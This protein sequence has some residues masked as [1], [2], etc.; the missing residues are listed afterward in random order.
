M[1]R[2]RSFRSLV[3]F[4]LLL[5]G[6]PEILAQRSE[7]LEMQSSTTPIQD[8]KVQTLTASLAMT[9]GASLVLSGDTLMAG[10]PFGTI[11]PGVVHIQRSSGAAWEAIASLRAPDAIVGDEFGR[12]LA[13]HGS[14]LVVG[15]PGQY[16]G[17]GAAYLFE[18]GSLGW[19]FKQ[20]LVTTGLSPGARFG[21][22]VAIDGDRIAVGAPGHTDRGAVITFRRTGGAW[23]RDAELT[24]DQVS[25][26]AN[27]GF[28]VGLT[29]SALWASAPYDQGYT[30]AIV[31]YDGTQQAW[32]EVGVLRAEEARGGEYFGYGLSVTEQGIHVGRLQFQNLGDVLIYE[33]PSAGQL[34][35]NPT[36]IMNPVTSTRGWFGYSLAR[37][38]D[39]LIV[40][41]P[42]FDGQVGRAYLYRLQNDQ[43]TL[44]SETLDLTAAQAGDRLG[45][46]VA[47]SQAVA[48]AGLYGGGAGPGV[49]ASARRVSG[50]W[51][52]SE[53]LEGAGTPEITGA[54]VRC[55]NGVAG[56]FPCYNVDLHAFLPKDQVG[57]LRATKL[58]DVWG[59]TDDE[60]GSKYVLSAR[61]DGLSIVMVDDPNHPLFLAQLPMTEGSRA[62]S[63]R[64]VK[65][66]GHYAL[67][68]GDNVGPHGMQVLD[69]TVLRTL[70]PTDAP[71]MLQ[72]TTIYRGFEEAHNIVVNNAFER[73]Y[74]VGT[75]T[76]GAGYHVIDMSD[77][78]NP[79]QIGCY[80]TSGV[81][82]SGTGYV[83]D[84]QCVRY[85]GPDLSHQG[86]D[87]CFGSN[88]THV[89]IT[90]F[91]TPSS[92]IDL[93]LANY[94]DYGYVHQAWLSD[95]HRYLYQ[96][97]ELDE[98]YG[99]IGQRT[100]V[101]DVEDLDDP[102]LDTVYA[103]AVVPTTDH[104]LY[105]R[106]NRVYEGN[107]ASGMRILDI[108]NP[109]APQ[110]IA[111][112]DTHPIKN[113]VGFDGVW[114]VYPFFED[115]PI[116][117]SSRGE[118]LF[119][120]SEQSASTARRPDT[121]PRAFV[122]APYPQPALGTVTVPIV[123]PV[124][125]EVSWTLIDV[126]GRP[127]QSG[128][129]TVSIGSQ[130]LDVDLGDLASGTYVLTL[131]QGQHRLGVRMI[132]K[133]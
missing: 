105:V 74:A 69:L 126:L 4:C 107:Y 108:S 49:I 103:G 117:I 109:R 99:G 25:P 77:P 28:R 72:E 46:A 24:S 88:E 81:G 17:R 36:H 75:E 37:A 124:T 78:T 6:V 132:T 64:D 12:A 116:V 60:T 11:E 39:A 50:S 98:Y 119:F 18:Y 87:I 62:N 47:L 123:V 115:G 121:L 125:G 21:F 31:Q 120:V 51:V 54:D 86:K 68:V 80:G 96:N 95:D 15:A 76:C 55:T 106:G 32:K 131:N 29:G 3:V 20:S 22:S 118:G 82:F 43:W 44:E 102:I 114:S 111:Y 27:L 7:S 53:P 128:E 57:A 13:T 56:P 101:W 34:A 10:A 110:E 112:F 41:Q 85:N 5:A 89:V 14:L 42:L 90:D 66:L 91:S 129:T 38:G 59:W 83:H 35:S 2:F 67:V 23:L 61:E 71:H 58:N 100:L 130:S 8:G 92:P 63:W 33:V 19:T 122:G 26:S 73:A 133:R 9:V 52:A 94:A 1:N 30:G 70:D 79:S 127:A 93:G 113:A 16:E 97:D 84:A 104:N 45:Y 48:A 65:T 40:G